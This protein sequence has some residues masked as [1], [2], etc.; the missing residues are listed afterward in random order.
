MVNLLLVITS[1]AGDSTCHF[2]KWY[3]SLGITVRV[4]S[5]PAAA[6]EGVAEAVPLPSVVTA[7]FMMRRMKTDKTVISD[8][9]D[10]VEINEYSALSPEQAALYHKTLDAAMAE[11]EGKDTSDSVALFERQGLILQMILALKQICNHPAQYLKNGN[12]SPS[13]SGKVEMLLDRLDGIVD[14]GEKVLVF[15][16]FKEMGEMLVK[17]VGDRTAGR[18]RYSF[19]P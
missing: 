3:S 12:M 7:P 4:I 19:F 8:L 6:V 13:L 16:Q 11:I 1:P 18:T 17:F 9:P 15:P 2:L 10:K 14:A 5:V